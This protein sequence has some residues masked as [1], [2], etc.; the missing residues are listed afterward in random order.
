MMDDDI[1][2]IPLHGHLVMK[3]DMRTNLGFRGRKDWNEQIILFQKNDPRF[4]AAYRPFH[5]KNHL[6]KD[7]AIEIIE[8]IYGEEQKIKFFRAKR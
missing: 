4:K 7:L 5:T 8:K 6:S 2:R 1:I 3:E